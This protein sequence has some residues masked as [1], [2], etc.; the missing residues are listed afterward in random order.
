MGGII[1]KRILLVF[2]GLLLA[3]TLLSWDFHGAQ[4]NASSHAKGVK[5][6]KKLNCRR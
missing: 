1:L 5:D 6:M 3:V 4:A 2:L